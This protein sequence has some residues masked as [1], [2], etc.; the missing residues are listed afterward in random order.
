M[1]LFFGMN[2]DNN[3]PGYKSE[4]ISALE[5]NTNEMM[6]HVQRNA[7]NIRSILVS[8]YPDSIPEAV[9]V[10]EY[11]TEDYPTEEEHPTEEFTVET[12]MLDEDTIPT[13]ETPLL[14][15]VAKNSPG[16]TMVLPILKK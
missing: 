16:I 10:V 2:S 15:N 4:R 1:G 8:T 11:I 5:I 13:Q 14:K 12:K 7:S 6:V 9:E 3:R